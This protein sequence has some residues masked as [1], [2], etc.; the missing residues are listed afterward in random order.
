MFTLFIAILGVAIIIKIIEILTALPPYDGYECLVG[1]VAIVTG[2]SRGIGLEVSKYLASRGCKVI[3]GCRTNGEEIISEI[4]HLTHNTNVSVKNVDFK[5]FTSVRKFAEE[6]HK[7]ETKIDIL[8]N[9]AG[10]GM[11]L[12]ISEDGLDSVV[13]VNALSPFL[14]THLL[15]DLLKKSEDPRIVFTTSVA[16]FY[17]NLTVESLESTND[18][19][20]FYF[21]HLR[22]YGNTKLALIIVSN[23]LSEKLKKHGIKSN[24]AHPGLA[25]SSIF[26]CLNYKH[27]LTVFDRC[28][29]CFIQFCVF[30][31]R[32]IRAT[33]E[34]TF[35][36]A[37]SDKYKDTTGQFIWGFGMSTIY[38][39]PS[40]LKNT[41]MCNQIWEKME[42]LVQLR[43][44]EKL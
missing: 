31:A 32:K 34:P 19:N 3:I 44:E 12:E 2:G 33:A 21:H 11:E 5:S 36:L 40:L 9:N 26:Q 7:T 41:V 20:T 8:I 39:C 6:I 28:S 29:K 15:I 10:V 43:P 13:Q 22:H 24:A 27:D 23:I 42:S 1:K 38:P 17:N 35:R 25:N 37:I 4:V 30:Y 14:L 16:A 18:V